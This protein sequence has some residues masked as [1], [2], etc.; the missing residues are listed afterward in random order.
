MTSVVV[1]KVV[2]QAGFWAPF[3]GGVVAALTGVGG[4]MIG[5]K[6]QRRGE[7]AAWRRTARLSAYSELIASVHQ[8]ELRLATY[9]GIRMAGRSGELA[10]ASRLASESVQE[11]RRAAA[12]VQ[13]VGP[14][15]VR[16]AANELSTSAWADFNTANGGR[17]P[18]STSTL[19]EK[20]SAFVDA[21]TPVVDTAS[22]GAITAVVATSAPPG[23][24]QDSRP[25]RP[26]RRRRKP[27]NP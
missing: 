9:L 24:E 3:V 1:V 5:A 17:N 20:T 26:W 11:V 19:T 8:F 23:P 12:A 21:S 25:W 16:R 10:E 7:E 27:G 13:L 18:G 6:M 2:E 4:V 14:N 22:A 15:S